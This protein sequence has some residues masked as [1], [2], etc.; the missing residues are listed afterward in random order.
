ME[1][2]L[3]TQVDEVIHSVGSATSEVAVC[4]SWILLTEWTDGNGGMWLEEYRTTGIAPWKRE[5]ILNYVL[6]TDV[7]IEADTDDIT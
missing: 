1:K 3:S 6:T 5:G 7:P 4:T 2:S